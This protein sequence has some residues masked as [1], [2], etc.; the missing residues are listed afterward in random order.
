MG[1]KGCKEKIHKIGNIINNESKEK[2]EMRLEMERTNKTKVTFT[3]RPTYCAKSEQSS[4]RECLFLF[5]EEQIALDIFHKVDKWNPNTITN[6]KNCK[7]VFEFMIVLKSFFHTV[8][9]TQIC[10]LFWFYGNFVS[11]FSLAMNRICVA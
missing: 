11:F 1:S 8:K 3:P 7:G 6:R 5:D 2:Q 4:Q 9:Y 10:L